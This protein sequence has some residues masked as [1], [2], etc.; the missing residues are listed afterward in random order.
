MTS[1]YWLEDPKILFDK[2]NITELW[3]SSDM[4][5]IEKMNTLCRLIIFL[6]LIGLIIFRS[7]SILIIGLIVLCVLTYFYNNKKIN[8]NEK[9]LYVNAS[10]KNN[11]KK[12]SKNTTKQT[13]ENFESNLP[14]KNN[15]V[16]I[17][18]DEII[19]KKNLVN[20]DSIDSTDNTDNT[21]IKV[22][23]INKK[24]NDIVLD[25]IT[26]D[27]SSKIDIQKSNE[28]YDVVDFNLIDF[29]KLA[30]DKFQKSLTINQDTIEENNNINSLFQKSLTIPTNTIENN[31]P[32]PLNQNTQ[33]TGDEFN[34]TINQDTIENNHYS[35]VPYK[36]P[37]AINTTQIH[38][39]KGTVNPIDKKT[40]TKVL[41][42]DTLFRTNYKNTNSSDFV[43]NLTQPETNVVSIKLSSVDIPISWYN[44]VDVME[45][46]KFNVIVSNYQDI[47]QESYT[48]TIPPGNYN[49]TTFIS[50][51]N[52]IFDEEDNILQNFYA[53]VN[54]IT[55][56][57]VF[58]LKNYDDLYN[59]NENLE[60]MLD[61]FIN[62]KNFSIKQMDYEFQKT[63]GW[64]IG[65][66]NMDYLMNSNNS[67]QGETLFNLKHDD[68]IFIN[69]D[70]Y[71][72]N[73]VCQPITSSTWNSYIG[74]NILGRITIDSSYKNTHYDNNSDHVFSERVYLGPVSLEKF[75]IQILNK[76]G[77]TIDLNNSNISFTLELTK[78]Y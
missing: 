46:N 49:N 7:L 33:L 34:N 5:Y 42:I 77:E 31:N 2:E 26:T 65:F 40:I 58:K 44:I 25:S 56:N 59:E 14:C 52:K 23:K 20:I 43:W 11:K 28:Q 29:F 55:K 3:P 71:N 48:V 27:E 45:R 12:I 64:N 36:Q 38:Y 54:E 18:T 73:C 62:K 67:I 30:G 70:D 50:T 35:L 24:I 57:I 61:F 21:D 15:K 69:L 53:E 9:E 32:Y 22:K 60:I 63:V 10:C 16:V 74:N 17:S 39:P 47:T 8:D 4:T 68:Y 78:I 76:F 66:R 75:K 51:I 1:V 6:T 13:K 72:S 41:N 19:S 37:N